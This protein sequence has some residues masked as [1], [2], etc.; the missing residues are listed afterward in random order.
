MTD[1]SV[2]H[3]EYI[4]AQKYRPKSIKECILP[5]NIKSKFQNFIDQGDIPNLLLSGTRGIGKTTVAYALMNDLGLD[6]YK[7]NASMDRGIDVL[8]NEIL[9]YASSVSLSEGRKFVILDEADNLTV[10]YQ[11]ALRAFTEEFSSNCGFIMTANYSQKIIDPLKGRFV[12]ILFNYNNQEKTSLLKQTIIRVLQILKLEN[13]KADPVIIKNLVVKLFPDIRTILN[14]IQEHAVS[15]EIDSSIMEKDI[16][17][18]DVLLE[19][20]KQKRFTD[21]RKW[22]AD[23]SETT[24]SVINDNLYRNMSEMVEPQSLPLLIDIMN[25]YDYRSYF[26]INKEIN[27]VAMLTKFMA[28]INWRK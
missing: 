13:I 18:F 10:S 27:V 2:K 19:S 1:I 5:E 21:M 26:V 16:A 6:Y 8:R 7:I 25:E 28:D 20:L 14:K 4:F 9:E 17:K 24:I 15:G 22:V 23:N 11:Q 12:E 3:N